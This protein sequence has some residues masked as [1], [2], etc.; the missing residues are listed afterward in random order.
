MAG[1]IFNVRLRFLP[2]P[3]QLPG[4]PTNV[5]GLV[6]CEGGALPLLKEMQSKGH[7]SPAVNSSEVADRAREI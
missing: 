1:Q 3:V 2:C 5:I 6:F 4:L 7:G